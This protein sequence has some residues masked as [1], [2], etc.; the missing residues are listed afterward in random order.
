MEVRAEAY[1]LFIQHE[2]AMIRAV[3]PPNVNL[4]EWRCEFLTHPDVLAEKF[5]PDQLDRERLLLGAMQSLAYLTDVSE[6]IS[7]GLALMAEVGDLF[8]YLHSIPLN[9]F[10]EVEHKRAKS[11]LGLLIN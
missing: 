1:R 9:N 5:I 10:L 4:N 8:T 2:E 7:T 6:R 3:L 11:S